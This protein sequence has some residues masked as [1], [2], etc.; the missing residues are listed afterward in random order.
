[1]TNP[2]GHSPQ[3]PLHTHAGPIQSPQHEA[4]IL[5]FLKA[6]Y[7]ETP[8]YPSVVG[9]VHSHAWFLLA[10]GHI[11]TKNDKRD[12]CEDPYF[13]KMS[14]PSCPKPITRQP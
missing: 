14:T 3:I 5:P 4:Q 8:I 11:F 13:G 9:F 7:K 1:M 2:H 10:F 12:A 6:K